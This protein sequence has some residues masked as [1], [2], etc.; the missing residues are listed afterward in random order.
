MGL[1]LNPQ[2]LALGFGHLL[3]I[4]QVTLL[5]QLFRKFGL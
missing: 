3:G 5:H 4:I 2:R 1:N